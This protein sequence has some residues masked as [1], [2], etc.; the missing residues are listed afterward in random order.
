MAVMASEEVKQKLQHSI[1]QRLSYDR[2]RTQGEM[3]QISEWELQ[4]EQPN[5]PP[6]PQH[7][8][9]E[10]YLRHKTT[11]CL[12]RWKDSRHNSFHGRSN[13]IYQLSSASDQPHHLLQ[14]QWDHSVHQMESLYGS[15]QVWVQAPVLAAHENRLN[16][17]IFMN[18]VF[19]TTAGFNSPQLTSLQPP[20]PPEVSIRIRQHR[21]L[22]SCQSQPLILNELP[23][24]N[25]QNHSLKIPGRT[26]HT[27]Q[28]LC[29]I[30][31]VNQ[32][33]QHHLQAEERMQE[34]GKGE[35]FMI[36]DDSSMSS[37]DD[38]W[39][40]PKSK[41]WSSS[42]SQ[43]KWRHRPAFRIHNRGH[44][45][46][47]HTHS[48]PSFSCNAADST[49]DHTHGTG[50]AYDP[51]IMTQ[52]CICGDVR[53]KIKHAPRIPL[54]FNTLRE[55]GVINQCKWITG[56][57]EDFHR[58]VV[59]RPF[60][61][62]L[63]ASFGANPLTD[64]HLSALRVAAGSVMNLMM[65]I[66]Q[67][68]LKNGF[69]IVQADR[70]DASCSSHCTAVADCSPVAIATKLLQQKHD[71]R[72]ILILHWD[73]H[74]CNSTQE[75]FYTDP[76]ILHISLHRY[77]NAPLSTVGGRPD[78]VGQ[79]DGEG[80]NVNVEWSCDRDPHIGDAE[81]LAAFRTVIRPIARQ[82]CPE[83]ILIS[84]E[85]NSVDGHPESQRGPRV[86]AQCFGLLTQNLMELCGG[87]VIVVLERGH[88]VTPVCEASTACVSALL[89]K[90]VVDL[91][92]DVLMKKPC[93]AAVQSLYKVLEIHSQY[94]S[95][96]RALI[97]TVGE[98]WLQTE[99][100]HSAQTDTASVLA[101]L[102]VKTPKHTS[103]E[104]W[105]LRGDGNE[106]VEHD[107]DQD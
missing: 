9:C 83:F 7:H 8:A 63:F 23:R 87:R 98:S 85:F 102:S 12:C 32:C 107:E 54:V 18:N 5:T 88:D 82:F 40:E 25:F 72:R 31:G 38:F 4:Q 78:E 46:L 61:K 69:A 22:Q 60:Q 96:V 89:E 66:T 52:H 74:H 71:K 55:N 100:K 20:A 36:G 42:S 29:V 10:C 35:T 58:E 28:R 39:E 97:H 91:S 95:S 94:W 13:S 105:R 92:E 45:S 26:S 81:Y 17:W 86:S 103:S 51:K 90:K 59:K 70:K 11:G 16:E 57:N 53:C 33:Q 64:Q 19:L 84:T 79:G 47:R 104:S 49:P 93:A 24:R 62:R 34:K 30:P 65:L 73:V 15:L 80:F 41:E 21:P 37:S 48:S 50:L 77:G 99:G 67:G 1:L 14:L 43:H 56:S 106:P 68:Q 101:L 27:K 44:Q 75:M 6:S 2:S 3:E 76:N